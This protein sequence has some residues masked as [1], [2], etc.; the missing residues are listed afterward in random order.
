VQIPFCGQTYSDRSLPANA[1]R[2]VNFYPML[3]PTPEDPQR[4]VLYPT[5]GYSQFLASSVTTYN[6]MAAFFGNR[7]IEGTEVRGALVIND[8]LYIV[9]GNAF[10]AADPVTALPTVIG[11]A[12]VSGTANF[13]NTSTG[14]VSITQ[15]TVEIAISDGSY[16]YLYNIS[17]SAFT[18]ITGGSFPAMGGVTNF[19]FQDGYVLA[20]V[21]GTRQ[22]IQSDLL[23]AGVYGTQATAQVLSFPD[24]LM[25]V[26][27]DDL[28]LYAFGP[29]ATEVRFNSAATPFA[30]QKTQGVLIPAGCKSI[31]TV[32]KVGGTIIW[33]ADDEA[34]S[35]YIAAL[36]GYSPKPISTPPMN[37]ALARYSTVSDAWAYSYREADNQFYVITFPTANATWAY[38]LK[39]GMWHEREYNGGKDLPTAYFTWGSYHIVG[40]ADGNLWLMGQEYSQA[41]VTNP[42]GITDGNPPHWPPIRTRTSPHLDGDGR[43]MFLDEF[44]IIFEAGPGQNSALSTAEDPQATLFISRDKGR[45]FVNVGTR[46]M[47]KIGQ[48]RQRLAWPRLGRARHFTFRLTIS[49]PVRTY[50]LGANAKIRM[51]TK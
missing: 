6:V 46:K 35:P 20:A 7:L 8:A 32:K 17:T 37:E 25:G 38:D 24:N 13:L 45:T 27:S 19:T 36:Q 2:T 26:F 1:Q 14:P 21:N 11:N 39:L 33:L 31:H 28:Q 34:G 51:A 23:S 43:Y 29:K 42:F 12:A 44:E 49:D 16:G 40:D 3:S 30:F 50:I 48:Y 41:G 4:I 10:F 22:I 5:P 47:G 15:N 9:I 18:I